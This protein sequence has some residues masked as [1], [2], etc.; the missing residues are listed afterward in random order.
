MALGQRRKG[1][2]GRVAFTGLP[3]RPPRCALIRGRWSPVT[4]GMPGQTGA[5]RR[6]WSSPHAEGLALPSL[7]RAVC[8]RPGAGRS[9][10]H[11]LSP[12]LINRVPLTM[13]GSCLPALGMFLSL[14]LLFDSTVAF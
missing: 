8:A 14:T 13:F 2:P 5:R 4:R 1:I 10:G 3:A 9:S 11:S 6:V 7:D 12:V